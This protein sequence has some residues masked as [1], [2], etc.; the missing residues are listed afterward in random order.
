MAGLGLGVMAYALFSVHDATNKYL[1]ASLPVWQVLFFRSVTIVIVCLA[2]G[3][4]K[5]L[6]RLVETPLKV[7]LAARGL[8]TLVAWM[9]YFSASRYLPLAQLLTLYFSAPILTTLLAKPLLGEHVTP[10]RWASVL[11]GFVGVVIAAD[12]VGMQA[13]W[14]MLLVLASA[15]MWGYAII[16]MRQIARQ[17]PSILQM[18]VQNLTFLVLT[19]ALSIF[20]WV[21]PDP[22]QLMLL[23]A[24]GVIGGIGQYCLFEGSRLAP[25]AVMSAMEYTSLLWAFVLGY[26]IFGDIP[27]L[28]VWIGAATILL[29]GV[30]L[31][32]SEWR[33]RKA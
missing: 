7:P 33:A 21:S 18:L 8:L 20:T 19:G 13:S 32:T 24:I 22:F 1:V 25:A 10:M 11:L 4:R 31:V 23:F 28:P 14:P 6:I 12:P 26:L 17:E 15:A 5:L 29:S 30:V 27:T 9:C 3:R 2:I 16:L